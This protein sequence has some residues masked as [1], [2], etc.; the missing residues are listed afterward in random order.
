MWQELPEDYKAF[1]VVYAYCCKQVL[2]TEIF[3]SLENERNKMDLNELKSKVEDVTRI[4]V[5][6]LAGETPEEVFSNAKAILALKKE[7]SEASMTPGRQFARWM[8]ATQGVEE[9]DDTRQV[10]ADL[11]D[12]EDSLRGY[13]MKIIDG[14]NPYI[15]GRRPPDTRSA[16]KQFEDFMNNKMAFNPFKDGDGWTPLGS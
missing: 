4:P 10:F 8:N 7:Q 16:S 11:E 2:I 9:V 13:S 3:T 6:L 5:S 15:N 14:G 1:C 12:L